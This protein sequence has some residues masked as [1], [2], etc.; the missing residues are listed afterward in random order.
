MYLWWKIHCT[1]RCTVLRVH[2]LYYSDLW[3]KVMWFGRV[4]GHHSQ[5]LQIVCVYVHVCVCVCVYTVGQKSPILATQEGSD[6]GFASKEIK[7]CLPTPGW[8]VRV[9]KWGISW[10]INRLLTIKFNSYLSHFLD[11]GS[12]V[13]VFVTDPFR[14]NS[15]FLESLVH[16][17]HPLSKVSTTLKPPWSS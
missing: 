12:T 7:Q 16:S 5:Q 6:S 10:I 17:R 13:H 9:K 15:N 2:L 3:G 8:Y 1:L 11:T 4:C 14:L